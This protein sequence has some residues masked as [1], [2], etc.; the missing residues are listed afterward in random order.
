MPSQAGLHSS[1][2]HPP[3]RTAGSFS[4]DEQPVVELLQALV[5]GLDRT[6]NQVRGDPLPASFE[7]PLMKEAQPRRQERDDSRRLVGAGGKRRGRARLVVVFQEAGHLVLVIEARVEV[8]ADRPRVPLAQPVVQPLVVR[9][10]EPLLLQRP[11]EIPVDLGHEAEAG[12]VFSHARGGSRPERL[13]AE[14]P[15]SLE[16]VGQ[17]QHGHVAADAVALSGN[18]HQ[19]R[20]HRL[21]G[22]GIRVVELQRVGPAGEVRIAPVSEH[23]PAMRALEPRV[24]LRRAREVV[25]GALN[26]VLGCAST[27]G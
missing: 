5:H 17:H 4:A 16:D 19:R 15:R 12:H 6:A 1:S 25:V 27:H 23:A 13:R 3:S 2:C 14:A 9:V 11:F 20:D 18:L 22:G 7:L 8:L 24:V 26:V 21:L 10:V